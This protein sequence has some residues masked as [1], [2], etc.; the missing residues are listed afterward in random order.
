MGQRLQ[1]QTLLKDLVG[2]T[3]FVY[4]QPPDGTQMKYPAIVYKRDYRETTFAD[5]TPYQSTKRYQVTIIDRDPDSEIPDKV[6]ALPMCT[7]SRH[8]AVDYLNHDI[9]DLYF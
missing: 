4:F 7:F 6:A 9:Y 8:F 2:P 5:N 3:G 1:L